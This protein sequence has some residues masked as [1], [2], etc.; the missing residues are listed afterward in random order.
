MTFTSKFKLIFDERGSTSIVSVIWGKA[1][2]VSLWYFFQ[3][4]LAN[5]KGGWLEG[6]QSLY[7]ASLAVIV[8]SP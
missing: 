8:T 5:Y 3:L 2:K 6:E 4:G 7:H 1:F